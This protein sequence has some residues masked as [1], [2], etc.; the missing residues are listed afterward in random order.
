MRRLIAIAAFALF[1]SVPVWAQHGGGHGGGGGHAGGGFSGGHASGFSGGHSGFSG[2][3]ASGGVHAYSGARSGYGASRGFSSPGM[4]SRG[5]SSRGLSSN[6]FSSSANRGPFLHNG[7]SVR[8]RTRG[9]GN[10]GFRNN[11]YGWRCWGAYGFP[12]WGYDPWLWS[13]D[14]NYDDSYNQNLADAAE[15]NRENLEEQQ[16]M[17]QEQA[18]GDQDAYV[19]PPLAPRSAGNGDQGGPVLPATVL[20]FR[21]QHKQEVQNYAIVGQ[22]L[23][24]FASQRT[25]KIP[26]AS[27]D[28]SAT[29][30]ANE[31]RGVTFRVPATSPNVQPMQGQPLAPV[32]QSPSV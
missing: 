10:F 31:E 12:Y 2:S 23:W 8:I 26:L 27:L 28:I 14:S 21:D 20:V 29:T 3:H 16:M 11:C 15:M 18:D 17:R 4:S 1:V 5:F 22:T 7:T 6:R 9:F 32:V 19:R 25:E 30:K 13:D 24:S